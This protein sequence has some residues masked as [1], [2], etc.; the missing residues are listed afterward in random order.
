M[1]LGPPAMGSRWWPCLL[2]RRGCC[3]W[4]VLTAC[5]DQRRLRSP[6]GCSGRSGPR[7]RS[8]CAFAMM[9]VAVA[10]LGLHGQESSDRKNVR[11]GVF[12][13]F[14]PRQLVISP[15][16][17]SAIL[18]SLDSQQVR[19]ASGQPESQVNV[20]L[21][22][23]AMEVS[24][25]Q[26]TFH[27]RSL[28][29]AADG[30]GAEGFQLSVPGKIERKYRGKLSLSADGVSLSPVVTMDIETAVVSIV[31]AEYSYGTPIE[32]LKAQAV[33]SRS[34]LIASGRRHGTHFD[35]CDTTHCQFLREPPEDSSPAM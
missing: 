27:S 14:H 5:R 7:M 10:L 28:R 23:D 21:R 29:V 4:Y 16:E 19:V 8:R 15:T 6:R 11:I 32:A 25:G 1:S 20:S 13:L 35:F 22:G 24:I 17:G 31:A 12:G 26:Q 30:D 33:A 34:Y 3:C 9:A 2:T 18:V